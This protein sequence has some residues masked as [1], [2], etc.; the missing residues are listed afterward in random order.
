MKAKEI[1]NGCL[2]YNTLTKRVERAIGKVGRRVM[3]M[4]HDQDT[5]LVKSDN[6]RRASELQVYNYL[7][8]KSKLRA[9]LERV[10]TLKLF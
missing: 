7:N 3:T 9:V 8:K 5:K 6:F 1:R 2:Y 4:V 10:A